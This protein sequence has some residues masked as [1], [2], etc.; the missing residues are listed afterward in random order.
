MAIL[1]F[2]FP[3]HRA[4]HCRAIW[5]FPGR[6]DP[7]LNL[8]LLAG[9][10][11]LSC[12]YWPWE[13]WLNS[14]RSSLHRFLFSQLPAYHQY[15]NLWSG[16]LI[17]ALTCLI[18][19]APFFILSPDS[20]R[21]LINLPQPAWTSARKARIAPSFLMP[22]SWDWPALEWHLVTVL[23]SD[24]SL[25]DLMAKASTYVLDYFWLVVY[26]F[27][28]GQI[29]PGKS[30]FTRIGTYSLLLV[31]FTLIASKVFFASVSN[32]ADSVGAIGLQPFPVPGLDRFVPLE[33]LHSIYSLVIIW[34][35]K[36]LI[37]VWL[38]CFSWEISCWFFWGGGI[39]FPH[40]DEILRIIPLR[41]LYSYLCDLLKLHRMIVLCVKWYW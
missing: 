27:I 2:S 22:T 21:N 11:K 15:R 32:L 16:V 5:I 25:A 4:D 23:E 3:G 33:Q 35:F 31:T 14:I 20:L 6:L 10:H 12:C 19:L 24:R 40:P 36:S 38:R 29:R 26:W 7:A 30:Q 28:Y 8:F 13:Q 17:F 39:R 37:P 9:E 18:V 1:Y 41:Q 34:R